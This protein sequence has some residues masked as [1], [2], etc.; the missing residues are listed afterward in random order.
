VK[1][2]GRCVE[3]ERKLRGSY[4]EAVRI[5]DTCLLTVRDAVGLNTLGLDLWYRPSSSSSYKPHGVAP[6]STHEDT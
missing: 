2:E 1:V 6:F 3:V 5:I 4:R